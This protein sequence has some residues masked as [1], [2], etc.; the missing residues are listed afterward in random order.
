MV[1]CNAHDIQ[2]PQRLSFCK[3]EGWPRLSFSQ[4]SFWF[5]ASHVEGAL[6]LQEV[7]RGS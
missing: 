1:L 7:G 3:R 5:E 6:N 2:M 4:W